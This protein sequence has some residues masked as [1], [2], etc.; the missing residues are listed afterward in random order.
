MY[1]T[2]VLIV[3]L[4][5]GCFLYSLALGKSP[6][7]LFSDPQFALSKVL[8]VFI[9]IGVFVRFTKFPKLVDSKQTIFLYSAP[10]IFL[11]SGITIEGDVDHG[12]FFLSSVFHT[13]SPL[14]KQYR[15]RTLVFF[16]MLTVIVLKR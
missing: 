5:L 14:S 15:D 10:F 3:F 8:L 1:V 9:G 2:V 13:F 11:T 16:I 12:I 6:I 7:A 4:L